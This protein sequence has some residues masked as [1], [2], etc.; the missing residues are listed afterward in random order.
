MLVMTDEIIGI[1]KRVLKGIRADDET[2]ARDV[3]HAVGPG[4]PFSR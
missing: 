4:R 1:V 3:I 2:I